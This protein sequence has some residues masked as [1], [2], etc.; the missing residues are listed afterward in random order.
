[1][2]H[3]ILAVKLQEFQ[4]HTADLQDRIRKSASADSDTLLK[5][6]AQLR[7]EYAKSADTLQN[8]LAN[9]KPEIVGIL[10]AGFNEIQ[11]I[12]QKT[13]NALNQRLAQYENEELAED[14]RLLLAEYELDFSML[15]MDR[16]LSV[17]FDA[18]AS[19]LASAKEADL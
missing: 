6:A 2:S 18:M 14:I 3:Q 9:S 4:T 13:K 12:I 15:A 17:S 11:P 1:M 19:A 5:E 7:G 16:A 10:S 8:K